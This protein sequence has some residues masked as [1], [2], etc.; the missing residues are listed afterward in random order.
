M[1][2]RRVRTFIGAAMIGLGLV[3]A[4]LYGSQGEWL[5]TVLGLLFSLLGITYLWAEVYTVSA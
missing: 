5:P 2:R 1:K 4:G 3:Q